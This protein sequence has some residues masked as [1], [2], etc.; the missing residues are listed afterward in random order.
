MIST[1]VA[2]LDTPDGPFTVVL[3]ADATLRF[4]DFRAEERTFALVAQLA[5]RAGRGSA[6]G[7]VLVQAMSPDAPSIQHA[8]HHDADAWDPEVQA[9]VDHGYAVGLVNYRGST[10]Y[11]KAWQ[12]VLEGDPGRPEIEDVVAG[13]DDLVARGLASDIRIFPTQ[14][15]VEGKPSRSGDCAEPAGGDATAIAATAVVTTITASKR[16]ARMW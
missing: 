8:S 15:G 9:F 13:R 1:T 6:A 16:D 3:D 11:G 10:G 5:G 14:S 2:T 12:D 7:R 4:P